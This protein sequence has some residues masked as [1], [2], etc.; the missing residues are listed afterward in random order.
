MTDVI[1]A[2]T[3]RPDMPFALAASET[4]AAQLATVRVWARFLPQADRPHEHH[5]MRIA[6]KR[7]RYGIDAFANVLPADALACVPALKSIQDALGELH[8]SDVLFASIEATLFPMQSGRKRRGNEAKRARAQRQRTSLESLLS[9]TAAER[10]AHHTRTLAIW[11]TLIASAALAPLDH[12][13]IALA[14][15]PS[16]AATQPRTEESSS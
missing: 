7:L 6:I 14:Q 2:R 9:I 12:A 15:L 3:L 10:D 5:Q 11:Q 4:L 13:V 16:S 8:D 1:A